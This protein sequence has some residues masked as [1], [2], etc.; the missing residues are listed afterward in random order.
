[1][2][3]AC[4]LLG[5]L[6]FGVSSA[7]AGLKDYVAR[8]DDSYTYEVTETREVGGCTV[9]VVRLT[10]QTW[11]EITWKH[12]LTIFAPAEIKHPDKSLLVIAGGDNDDEGPRFDSSEL[13]T[14]G[15]IASQTGSVCAAVSQI[16]NQPLFDGKHEDAIIAYTEEQFVEGKGEDW[17]LLFPMVKSAVRAMDTVQAVAR[18]KRGAE[19]K[20]FV[21]TGASKRGW[22]SWLT[23]AADA[24]VDA[25][26]PIVIDVLNMPAQMQHQMDTYGGFSEEVADYTERGLQAKMAT[27]MGKKLLAEV[28][29][30]SFRNELELTKLI[31]IGTNDPYWTV[32][33]A[34]LYFNDLK[35]AHNA[36]YYQANTEH[37]I[38]LPG[39]ATISAFYHSRL[40]NEDFPKV[41]WEQ[42]EDAQNKLT[43]KWSGQGGKAVLWQATSPNRDFRQ[44]QWTSSPLEGVDHVTVNVPMPEQGYLAYYVEVQFPGA[45][46]IPYGNCSKITVLPDTFAP[47]GQRTYEVKAAEAASAK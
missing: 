40:K 3:H 33:A 22:T 32:D 9:Y 46:G 41:T 12:W 1:M 10:S 11:L 27:E 14:L 19:V 26:A 37:D 36:L 21:L 43:V 18:E 8:P 17:P 44:S 31:V 38:S 28:D 24:R 39:V 7:F 47:A 45:M 13:K 29:P 35:G 23:S 30:Y 4:L 2:K 15:I 6:I 42:A 25:I 16:P 34:N 5:V 20:E